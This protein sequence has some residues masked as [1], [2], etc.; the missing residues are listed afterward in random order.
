MSF[1]PEDLAGGRA[2]YNYGTVLRTSQDMFGTSIFAFVR[3]ARHKRL[4]QDAELV[5]VGRHD[6]RTP[7]GSHLGPVARAVLA[8]AGCPVLL[9]NPRPGHRRNEHHRARG[10]R[11]DQDAP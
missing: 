7:L 9:A 2:I 6:P 8:G 11:A 3:H 1:T 4:L 5:V 10:H